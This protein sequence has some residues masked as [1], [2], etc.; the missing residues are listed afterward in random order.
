VNAGLSRALRVSLIVYLGFSV[1]SDAS[2]AQ[3]LSVPET[4]SETVVH[5]YSTKSPGLVLPGPGMTQCWKVIKVAEAGDGQETARRELNAWAS[6]FLAGLALAE[7][8]QFVAEIT[9]V[10][11]TPIA[12]TDDFNGDWD[13]FVGHCQ[14]YS[15][16][17][18][19]QAVLAQWD[20]LEDDSR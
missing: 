4:G 15:G 11:G 5:K 10:E 12:L 18:F 17:N 9:E 3:D 7:A 8:W 6:G 16:D 2:Q 19:A 1:C 13:R 20:E 14:K